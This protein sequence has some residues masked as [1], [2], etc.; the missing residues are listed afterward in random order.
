[1]R[2]LE[3]DDLDTRVVGRAIKWRA[4]VLGPDKSLALPLEV[5]ERYGTELNIV[6]GN[7]TREL[8]SEP[9]TR[10][11]SSLLASSQSIFPDFRLSKTLRYLPAR[12]ERLSRYSLRSAI[13]I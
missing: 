11:R 2:V 6:L 1:M 4:P 8:Y 7:G 3:V 12:G 13:A 5:A 10:G 9:A